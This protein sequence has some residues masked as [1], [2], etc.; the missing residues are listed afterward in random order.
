[1]EKFFKNIAVR[2]CFIYLIFNLLTPSSPIHAQFKINKIEKSQSFYEKEKNN[3]GV[4]PILRYNRVQGITLGIDFSS[5]LTK[6]GRLDILGKY[7]YGFKDQS[8]YLIGLQRSFFNLNFLTIGAYYQDLVT[9]QDD[10]FISYN[11]NSA[12]AFFLKEDFMDYYIKKG[13]IGFIDQKINEVHTIRFEAESFEY[14]SIERN[15]NWSIFGK[16][17]NFRRNSSIPEEHGIAARF[18]WVFD[19]RDN[20]LMPQSGWYIEGKAEQT[21]GDSVDTK[22]LFLTLKRFQTLFGSHLIKIKLI[23]GT[24]TGCASRYDQYLMD[25]GGIGS[26]VAY[27]DKEFTNG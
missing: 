19:W 21:L 22:G 10:W 15:T 3:I 27:K 12:A 1:M 14:G 24:R 26:L 8:R 18:L 20:S 5:Q 6:L 2:I 4:S 13:A 16:K 9:S 7:C 23:A 17:K 11:E 25:M